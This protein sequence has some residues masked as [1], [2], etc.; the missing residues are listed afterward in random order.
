MNRFESLIQAG[1]IPLSYASVINVIDE[2][3]T[4]EKEARLLNRLFEQSRLDIT[5]PHRIAYEN[6][7]RAWL[8]LPDEKDGKLITLE[9]FE[10]ARAAGLPAI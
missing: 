5:K 10:A 1:W 8:V 2:A 6:G 9:C 7:T 3:D 4:K